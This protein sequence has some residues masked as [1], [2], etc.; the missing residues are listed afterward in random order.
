MVIGVG[1]HRVDERHTVHVFGQ[2]RK[3][4]GRPSAALA[5]LAPFERGSHERADGS[6]EEACL[7]VEAF[8]CLAVALGEFGLV[9]PGVDLALSAV[10]EQPDDGAR[11]GFVMGL[12]GLGGGMVRAECFLLEKMVCGNCAKTGSCHVQ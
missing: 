2:V 10:H 7:R 8:E 9:I 11:F 5:V 1:V 12:P 6:W 3:E 4:A